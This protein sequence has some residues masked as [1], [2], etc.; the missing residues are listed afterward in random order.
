MLKLHLSKYEK[1]IGTLLLYFVP[2]L[3]R[4]CSWILVQT[5]MGRAHMISL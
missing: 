5:T 1:A 4:L 2:I 3:L